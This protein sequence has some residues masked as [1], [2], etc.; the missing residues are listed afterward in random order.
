MILVTSIG[1]ERLMLRTGLNAHRIAPPAKVDG[2]LCVALFIEVP[3][4]PS[5]STSIGAGY[6]RSKRASAGKTFN[7]ANAVDP[8]AGLPSYREAEVC[9]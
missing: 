1:I 8:C 7:V 2:A 3:S 4:R 5:G 9:A 6:I